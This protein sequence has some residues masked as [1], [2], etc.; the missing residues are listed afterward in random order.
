MMAGENMHWIY[1]IDDGRL[2][3]PHGESWK[4]RSGGIKDADPLPNV[5]YFIGKVRQGFTDKRYQGRIGD[6]WFCPLTPEKPN[7][8]TGIGIHPDGGI[9]GT[10]GCIGIDPLENTEALRVKLMHAAGQKLQAI[11]RML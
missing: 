3:A 11:S 2:Y 5:T 7:G 9:P 10:E 6:P 4:A 8:R 1:S